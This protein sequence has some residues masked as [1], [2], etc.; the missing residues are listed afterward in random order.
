MYAM[1]EKAEAKRACH[2]YKFECVAV[3][4]ATVEEKISALLQG[5]L[6]RLLG[7]HFKTLRTCS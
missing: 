2:E 6:T 4:A 7:L 5:T 3:E 1:H